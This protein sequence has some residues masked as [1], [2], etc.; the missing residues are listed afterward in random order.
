MSDDGRHGFT[1]IAFVG[2]VFSPY[3]HWA[4]RRDPE[5]HCAVNV[6]L[7]GPKGRWAMTERGR[8]HL[9]RDA[10]SY[11]LRNS[12]LAWD[13]ESLTI[14]LDERCA[15]WPKPIRG[16]AVVT[17]RAPTHR[18]FHLDA[19]GR[20]R[21]RPISPICDFTIE[22]DAPDLRW[23]GSAYLDSNDGDEPLQAAFRSWDWAR[24]MTPDGARILYEVRRRDRADRDIAI[25]ID[26]AGAV[27]PAALPPRRAVA[28]SRIWRM[29][30]RIRCDEGAVA[31][32]M[33][34]LEDAPFY[35]RSTI[36][37]R[38]DGVDIAWLHESLDLDRLDRRSTRL[39]LPFRMPR[40]G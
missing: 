16:R 9:T 14:T 15:P 17:P 40:L 3:Y 24:A 31:A 19:A 37:A 35:S 33:E 2:S 4:G 11:Q 10:A 39:M 23:R 28:R 18:V 6:A 22:L 1:L 21:W 27:T 36:G 20:H 7:Y 13:G 5:N 32:P 8:G 30:R 25:A 34:R 12:A 26:K 29:P 38:L